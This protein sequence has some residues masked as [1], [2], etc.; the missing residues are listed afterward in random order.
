MYPLTVS[1]RLSRVP[2]SGIRKIFEEVNRLQQEGREIINLGIGRPDFDTPQHIKEATIAALHEGF[3]HYTSNYGTVDLRKAIQ[4]K[5]Q[6]DNNLHVDVDEIIVTLGA[7]EAVFI[8]MLG[9]LDPGDEVLIP[10]PAWPHY[11]ACVE[12]VGGKSVPYAMKEEL[13]FSMD[14]SE[15]ESLITDRTKMLVINS[16]QNPTGA[17]LGRRELEQIAALARKYN[18]FVLSDEIYEKFIYDQKPHYSLAGFPGM[19]ERTLIV[20]GFSKV[21]SMTGWRVGFLAGPKNLISSL[22]K[23]HQYAVTCAVSFAQVGAAT[24]LR[25]SQ[26]CVEQM[27]EEFSR[28]RQLL[29]ESINRIEGLSLT[30][31]SGAFMPLSM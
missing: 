27:V 18:L 17:V 21:Y 22:V 11:A 25:G 20:N 23:A 6:E 13:H 19:K 16:P 3:V 1:K 12:L 31:P 9:L 26:H 28:R 4:Q 29:V 5:L 14:P 8:A 30:P 24:A 10:D 15:L 7:S 2:F